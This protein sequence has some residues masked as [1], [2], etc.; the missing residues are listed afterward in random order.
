M[1]TIL[2]VTLCLPHVVA[3]ASGGGAPW[4]DHPPLPCQAGTVAITARLPREVRNRLKKLA[5]DLERTMNDL[6]AE[7]LE[8]LFAKH[9][10]RASR[11]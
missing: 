9:S 8:D 6:I 2:V 7:A 10:K 5:I 4:P 11:R 3:F 1:A